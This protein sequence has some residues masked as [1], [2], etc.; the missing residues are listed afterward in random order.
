MADFLQEFYL[1]E[2]QTLLP[3]GEFFL[4][5]LNGDQLARMLIFGLVDDP[6]GAV[7]ER[8]H[9]LKPLYLHIIIYLQNSINKSELFRPVRD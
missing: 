8:G 9:H 3:A 1:F 5:P 4:H 6:I 2:G 7:T